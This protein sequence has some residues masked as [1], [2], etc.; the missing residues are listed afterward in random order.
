[1]KRMMPDKKMPIVLFS[2]LTVLLPCNLFYTQMTLTEVFLVA[3]YIAA[4]S[5]LYRYLENN[6]LSTLLLLMLILI[7]LYTVHMRTVGVLLAAM[8]VVT[9]HIFLRGDKRWHVLAALGARW[10]CLRRRIS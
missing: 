8:I 4:G 1:M 10:R 9:I 7:Y 2:A 3:L 5:V 6:R